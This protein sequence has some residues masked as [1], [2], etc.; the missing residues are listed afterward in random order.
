MLTGVFS[1]ALMGVAGNL[2]VRICHRKVV[3]WEG[4]SQIKTNLDV[5]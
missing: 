1:L 2:V 5:A 3:F 4:R